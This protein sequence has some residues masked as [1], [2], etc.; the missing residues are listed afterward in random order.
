MKA[1]GGLKEVL[2][3]ISNHGS[4]EQP[5]PMPMP[6]GYG[7]VKFPHWRWQPGLVILAALVMV[8]LVAPT[9]MVVDANPPRQSQ[10]KR[11]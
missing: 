3:L 7:T 6:K 10:M 1:L 5:D 8:L 4:I 9:V 2:Q 11:K